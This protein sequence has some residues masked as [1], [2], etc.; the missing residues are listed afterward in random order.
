MGSLVLILF[1]NF[2]PWSVSSLWGAP[3]VYFNL[4]IQICWFALQTV[5][6]W[7]FGKIINHHTNVFNIICYIIPT[8]CCLLPCQA[9]HNHRWLHCRFFISTLQWQPKLLQINSWM[10]LSASWEESTIFAGCPLVCYA[11]VE[12]CFSRVPPGGDPGED[13]RHAWGT[14]SLSLPGNTLRSHSMSWRRWLGQGSLDISAQT[15]VSIARLWIKRLKMDGWL[16][17][18]SI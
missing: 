6:F 18:N 3:H 2:V 9:S 12:K 11:S 14:T 7:P 8:F 16:V 4:R 5:C 13:P 1:V 10:I 17:T 15:V